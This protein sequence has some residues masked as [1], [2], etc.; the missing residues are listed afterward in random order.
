MLFMPCNRYVY[1]VFVCATI[2]SGFSNMVGMSIVATGV[3]VESSYSD[4]DGYFF[5]PAGAV[6]KIVH[7]LG[8]DMQYT[9]NVYVVY[10]EQEGATTSTLRL[11][12]ENMFASLV[13]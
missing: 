10:S 3:S 9:G 13:G 6:E 1:C 8:P 4:L 2:V 11:S 5:S 7:V 12:K